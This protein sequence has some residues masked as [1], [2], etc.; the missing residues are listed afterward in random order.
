[1]RTEVGGLGEDLGLAVFGGHYGL[2]AVFTSFNCCLGEK[3][4]D[5]GALLFNLGALLLQGELHV[6]DAA[7]VLVG[8]HF[9]ERS[10]GIGDL[11]QIL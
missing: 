1:M 3:L 9:V 4:V 8:L 7:D 11:H 6:G 2:R 10:D 5:D